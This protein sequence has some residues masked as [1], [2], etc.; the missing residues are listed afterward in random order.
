MRVTYTIL[1]H[2]GNDS[3]QRSLSP[4]QKERQGGG[5]AKVDQCFLDPAA[6]ASPGFIQASTFAELF[7]KDAVEEESGIRELLRMKGGGVE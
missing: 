7:Q 1:K 2:V 6:I 5:Y 3:D 4:R